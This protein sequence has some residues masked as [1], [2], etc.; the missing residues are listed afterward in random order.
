[1]TKFGKSEKIEI[2][3]AAEAAMEAITESS[4]KPKDVQAL[5]LGNASGDIEE[6]QTIM[7]GFIADEL[8]IAGV[9]APRFESACSSGSWAVATASM[10]VASGFFDIVLAVGT[11]RQSVL[12][13]EFNHRMMGSGVHSFYESPTG[14][15]FPGLFGMAAHLYAHKYSIPL[16]RFKD[17]LARVA[18][19]NHKN[20]TKN[21]K[22]QFQKE[23]TLED[24]Y[25]SMP[26]ASPLQLYDCCPISDGGAAAIIT[27]ADIAK[28]LVKKPV[29]VIGIGFSSSGSLCGQKDFTRVKAREISAKMAYN[30]A[31][32]TP[33]DIDV[34]EL[35]DCFT[36]AEIL[37]TEG[38]GLFEAGD[39]YKALE[40][41]DTEIGNKIP[42]NP[43]GGL[44]AKGHPVGATGPAQVYEITKQIRGECGPRQVDGARIG[45][46]D[47]M[48]GSFAAM[49]NL[50]L[51]KGW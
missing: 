41:G 48:G 39:G 35:H 14:L 27:T 31:G 45:I 30:M 36:I 7:G 24:Y 13:T 19:K 40:R 22:A 42:C 3:L 6:N 12:S 28:K 11:E 9:P 21:P 38:L 50:I 49:V 8:G 29:H 2:E 44:K 23:I 43:S 18:M 20:G 4:L 10:W 1:M 5:M 25:N 51:K 37:A 33:K 15:S 16:Q 47:T 32:I 17:C 46:T 34:A 26:V